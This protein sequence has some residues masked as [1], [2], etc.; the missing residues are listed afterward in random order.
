MYS[1]QAN[2]AEQTEETDNVLNVPADDSVDVDVP[3]DDSVDDDTA[4]I[5]DEQICQQKVNIS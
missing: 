1:S 5:Q 2:E 4:E 3:A